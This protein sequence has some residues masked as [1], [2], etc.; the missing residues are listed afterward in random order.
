MFL[1][2]VSLSFQSALSLSLSPKTTWTNHKEKKEIQSKPYSSN[3]YFPLF[4]HHKFFSSLFPLR[5]VSW[6]NVWMNLQ[7]NEWGW[8]ERQSGGQASKHVAVVWLYIHINEKLAK[9]M[10]SIAPTWCPWILVDNR[11]MFFCCFFFYWLCSR[12]SIILVAQLHTKSGILLTRMSPLHQSWFLHSLLSPLV[13][14]SINI[15]IGIFQDTSNQYWLLHFS[16]SLSFSFLFIL[17]FY[18]CIVFSSLEAFIE[19]ILSK[20]MKTVMELS[21]FLI[22]I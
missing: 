18:L 1:F 12:H 16:S 15:I 6:M 7:M 11:S 8:E 9:W 17:H 21:F 2:S 22:I 14:C 5:I 13:W 19:F 3:T 10:N 20:S 4:D